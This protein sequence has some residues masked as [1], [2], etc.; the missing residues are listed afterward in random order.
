ML[1]NAQEI[2]AINELVCE[3]KITTFELYKSVESLSDTIDYIEIFVLP[4][5]SDRGFVCRNNGFGRWAEYDKDW[6]NKCIELKKSKSLL[7]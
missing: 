2:A 5:W 7:V 3:H 1:F 4:I 6:L